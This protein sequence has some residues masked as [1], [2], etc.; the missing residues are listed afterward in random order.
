MA[1]RLS[2]RM[3]VGPTWGKPYAASRWR[4]WE[5]LRPQLE[6]QTYSASMLD[7]ETHECWADDEQTMGAENLP[8][9]R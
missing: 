8:M 5:T 1:E 4:K 2:S 6:R 3:V 7:K 9:E